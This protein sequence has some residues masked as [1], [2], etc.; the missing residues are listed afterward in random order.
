[1]GISPVRKGT[2]MVDAFIARM[3]LAKRSAQ[4]R[5]VR[6][7]RNR[8]G[9]RISVIKRIHNRVHSHRGVSANS[10]SAERPG[11]LFSE[12]ASS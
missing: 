11:G 7:W 8:S 3:A 5:N 10:I 2:T 4:K 9:D 6:C 1:M 12:E